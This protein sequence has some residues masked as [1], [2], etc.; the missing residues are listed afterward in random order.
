MKH[1]KILTLLSL[2]LSLNAMSQAA[3]NIP[4]T[5]NPLWDSTSMFMVNGQVTIYDVPD[6][7]DN[8]K[9]LVIDTITWK[10]KK[11]RVDELIQVVTPGV[12]ELESKQNSPIE[13]LTQPNVYDEYSLGMNSLTVT[14]NP[15]EI[16]MIAVNYSTTFINN[17][18]VDIGVIVDKNGIK[19]EMLSSRETTA[20]N[21]VIEID[22][23]H[24][25]M[26]YNPTTSPIT[27]TFSIRMSIDNGF[28]PAITTAHI[29]PGIMTIAVLRLSL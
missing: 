29:D 25:Y 22:G 24:V 16:T 13:Y 11:I 6:A 19:Q 4:G 1:L 18:L 8:Y 23:S 20:W 2:S 21:T 12:V 5:S 26:L 27:E 7:Y 17:G 9:V 3:I 14:R 28:N 10:V 15:G